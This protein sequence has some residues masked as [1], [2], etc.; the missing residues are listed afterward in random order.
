[1]PR[2]HLY[3]GQRTTKIL[4][5]N[6][7]TTVFVFASLMLIC[8]L[9]SSQCSKIRVAQHWWRRGAHLSEN[10]GVKSE[11]KKFSRKLKRNGFCFNDLWRVLQL[12][13][14][15][16]HYAKIFEY[17]GREING[18]LPISALKFSCQRSPP[19]ELAL[20]D[21]SVRS[22]LKLLFYLQKSRLQC[23]FAEM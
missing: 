12:T 3:E 9:Q 2:Y 5:N 6:L 15:A 16:F 21:R 22:D 4:V 10:K 20:F 19:P 23:Q 7:E 1:M 11:C 17:F 8:V 18:T 13:R 14:R